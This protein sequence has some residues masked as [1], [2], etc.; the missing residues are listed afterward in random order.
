[1]SATTTKKKKASI[2]RALREQVW[3]ENIGSKFEHKCTVGWCKNKMNVFDF[4]VGHNIPE[5]K[6]GSTEITNLK[7]ICSRCNLSMSNHYSITEWTKMGIK[8][9]MKV[10]VIKKLWRLL[11]CHNATINVTTSADIKN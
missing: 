5:S 1:M 8:Q 6:G 7:P 4:H 2:P 9:E 3:I 11:S 10:S